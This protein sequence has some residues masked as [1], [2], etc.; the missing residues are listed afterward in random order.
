MLGEALSFGIS[1]IR[2][3]L[4]R[5]VTRLIGH[6][7]KNP[8]EIRQQLHIAG[9]VGKAARKAEFPRPMP[10]HLKSPEP[11]PGVGE[12]VLIDDDPLLDR[13]VEVRWSYSA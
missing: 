8:D 13:L 10:R 1:D 12:G 11:P 7:V 2:I 5:R 6:V 4:Q 3:G 9:A